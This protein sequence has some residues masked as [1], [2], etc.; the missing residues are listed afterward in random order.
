MTTKIVESMSM[1]EAFKALNT[2]PAKKILEA[3]EAAPKIPSPYN[4]YFEVVDPA[5][6]EFDDGMFQIGEVVDGTTILAYLAPKAEYEDKGIFDSWYFLIDDT[7]Y[8]VVEIGGMNR[9][10][11]VDIEAIFGEIKR[12]DRQLTEGVSKSALI[13]WLKDHAER[14]ISA[15]DFNFLVDSL[16]RVIEREHEELKF[17]KMGYK[18]IE[19]V[20]VAQLIEASDNP[21]Y[22]IGFRLLGLSG[23]DD[24]D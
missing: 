5:E 19:D 13:R 12:T 11:P 16:W 17:Y 4:K 6:I 22:D 15:E 3:A 21:I 10:Y 20:D 18:S 8:P 2:K 9:M 14:E 23:D 7:Q 1:E 24:I